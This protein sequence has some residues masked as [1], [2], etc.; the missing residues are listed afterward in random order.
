MP[1]TYHNPLTLH[2]KWVLSLRICYRAGYTHYFEQ[3][4]RDYTARGL[5]RQEMLDGCMDEQ[6]KQ[7]VITCL[8]HR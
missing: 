6:M 1:Y 2:E 3:Y 5:T 7:Q 4:V 8:E